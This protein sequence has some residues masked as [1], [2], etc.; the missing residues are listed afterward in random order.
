MISK[1][2]NAISIPKRRYYC[3]LTFSE[4]VQVLYDWLL[5]LPVHKHNNLANKLEK[6][7]R[8]LSPWPRSYGGS[9]NHK[10]IHKNT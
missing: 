3:I 2:L 9:Q 7:D 8:S 5:L 1:V 4:G 6:S 10:R